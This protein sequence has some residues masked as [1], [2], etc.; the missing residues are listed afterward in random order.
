MN[1]KAISRPKT[2]QKGQSLTSVLITL[3]ISMVV[4]LG[5]LS[6][7][8]NL[9]KEVQYLQEKL[10]TITLK[11]QLTAILSNSQ[12]CTFNI[13]RA[14]P[15][16]TPL[17]IDTTNTSSSGFPSQIVELNQIYPQDIVTSHFIAKK[18]QPITPETPLLIVDKVQITDFQPTGYDTNYLAN[19]TISFTEGIRPMKPIKIP[20]M[21]VVDSSTKNTPA[22][23]LDVC[24]PSGTNGSS[25]I[26][27]GLVCDTCT[28][29]GTYGYDSTNHIP[30]Y[31]ESSG[32]WK[33]LQ[34][35]GSSKTFTSNGTFT[36]TPGIC[37]LTYHIIGGGGAG[38]G[39]GTNEGS[40]AGGGAGG[41]S[42]GSINVTVGQ[43][44]TI[45]VGAGG[46]Y[47]N[48]GHAVCGPGSN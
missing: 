15:M 6:F 17:Q 33:P 48:Y 25:V 1:S 38:A 14:N 37:R 42:S 24:G 7:M 16:S 2:S 35:Q 19:W 44:F 18:N 10:T 4:F 20:T 11:E 39:G 12:V 45:T 32:K 22:T 46:Q 8:R 13:K 28:A 40:G 30:I 36:I 34:S 29:E 23:L 21:I 5:I 31:C 3:G 27:S 9:N 43:V 41:Y 47:I 26:A